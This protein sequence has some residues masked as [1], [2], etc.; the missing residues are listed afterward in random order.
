MK[1]IIID[2]DQEILNFLEKNLV[3]QDFEI[4]TA[5]TGQEGLNLINKNDYDLI[6]LDLNLPDISGEEICKKLRSDRQSTPIIILSAEQ[7]TKNK[8]NLLDSGADEYITKPFVFEE[9][10]ARVNASLR[11]PKNIISPL[12]K[13]GD[14]EINKQKQNV[15]RKGEEIYLTRKEFL[16]LEYL[17]SY[18]ETIISKNELMEHI[19]D[20]NIN[21]FSKT[22]EMHITNLRRKIG[23]NKNGPIIKTISGRGY[24]FN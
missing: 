7:D 4:D 2:D 1:L 13:I 6:I 10:L 3:N 19:W 14:I 8:I 23:L 22:I 20:A 15:T 5:K 11:R 17:M 9:L 21:F 24:K 12:I 16:I 18:P